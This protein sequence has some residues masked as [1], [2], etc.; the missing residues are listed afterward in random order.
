[1]HHQQ[2]STEAM[3]LY[4]T[5]QGYTLTYNLLATNCIPIGAYFLVYFAPQPTEKCISN[6]GIAI[7]A[8]QAKGAF[9]NILST[10]PD[11]V[12]TRSILMYSTNPFL[13]SG[14]S[15]L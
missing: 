9:S 15:S 8:S 12:C 11:D 13:I 1:M 4:P 2:T 5:F 3:T 6:K 10:G 14:T 7:I